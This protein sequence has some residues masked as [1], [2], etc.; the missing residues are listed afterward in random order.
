MISNYCF[1]RKNI[2]EEI[3]LEELENSIT[4]NKESLKNSIM[5]Q[6]KLLERF[7]K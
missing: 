2:L 6:N 5:Y 7:I 3:K 1:S 4:L